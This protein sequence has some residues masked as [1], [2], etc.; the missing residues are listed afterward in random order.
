MSQARLQ[1]NI[2]SHF[3]QKLKIMS[4]LDQRVTHAENIDA[5]RKFARIASHNASGV[6][7]DRAV[8][9]S[10]IPIPRDATSVATMMGLFPVLNSFKTQSRSFCCLSPWMAV[11]S[12]CYLA[13][14]L[15]HTYTEPAIHLVVR[16]E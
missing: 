14:S 6:E 2:S 9:Q 3:M 15:I 16:S 7:G 5:K 1:V 10:I 4:S 13:K 11:T 8:L 12:Q